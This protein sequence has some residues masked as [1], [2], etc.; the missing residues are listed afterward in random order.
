MAAAGAYAKAVWADPAAKA[1]YEQVRRARKAW[2]AFSLAS[3]DFL[4][5]PEIHAIEVQ[6]RT[7]GG[8]PVVRIY[9]SDDIGVCERW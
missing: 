7:K 6:S 2:R 1:F 8:S 3:D 9:A 5:A 4:N